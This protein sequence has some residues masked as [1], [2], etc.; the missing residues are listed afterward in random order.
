MSGSTGAGTGLA[1]N[2]RRAWIVVAMLPLLG[3]CGAPA[4]GPGV[5]AEPVF[6]AEVPPDVAAMAAPNQDLSNVQLMPE[7]RCYW[8]LH[9]GPVESVM[10]PLRSLEGDMICLRSVGALS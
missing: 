3:A 5:A 7:D 9:E 10:V 1:G 8:Y 2:R 6:I 4:V